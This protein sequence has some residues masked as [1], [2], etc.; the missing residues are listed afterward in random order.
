MVIVSLKPDKTS[1]KFDVYFLIKR[2][3][4]PGCRTLGHPK[5]K[6]KSKRKTQTK[7]THHPPSIIHN[8]Y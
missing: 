7:I 4:Y 6:K 8:H 3:M 2:V 5:K 1:V